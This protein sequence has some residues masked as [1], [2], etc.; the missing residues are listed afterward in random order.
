MGAQV[1]LQS[2]V[3][4]QASIGTLGFLTNSRQLKL[5][6][7]YRLNWGKA[8]WTK[9]AMLRL[10]WA[11]R[12]LAASVI[13]SG[14]NDVVL[15]QEPSPSLSRSMPVSI[16]NPSPATGQME[17]S[18]LQPRAAPAIHWPQEVRSFVRNLQIYYWYR[19][20]RIWDWV[21][22]WSYRRIVW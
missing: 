21:I 11:G 1:A 2:G 17:S 16:I 8:G 12:R 9:R 7:N 18:S 13:L 5:S 4:L 14:L 15:A 6:T 10:I 3:Q 22:A 19:S 20:Y